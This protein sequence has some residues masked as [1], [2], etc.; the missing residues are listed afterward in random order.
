MLAFFFD[1]PQPL[2]LSEFCPDD[3]GI[4]CGTESGLE[5]VY[6]GIDSR[7]RSRR[8]LIVTTNLTLNELQHPQDIAL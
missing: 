7:C 4:E 3:S 2:S 6:N 8:P 1:C 5:Q